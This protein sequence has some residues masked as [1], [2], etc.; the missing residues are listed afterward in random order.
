MPE[1]KQPPNQPLNQYEAAFLKRL[2][3]PYGDNRK[4]AHHLGLSVIALDARA[5]ELGIPKRPS[6]GWH[7]RQP[8]SGGRRRPGGW[9]TV[10]SFL[11][12]RPTRLSCARS[13]GDH[14]VHI[15][16]A[17]VFQVVSVKYPVP[18]A[19]GDLALFIRLEGHFHQAFFDED[20][21]ANVL[22][23]LVVVLPVL[24]VAP[25]VVGD[26]RRDGGDGDHQ[27]GR[28]RGSRPCRDRCGSGSCRHGRGDRCG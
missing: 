24:P 21:V 8:L 11:T 4:L 7:G 15:H 25:V 9:R 3:Q 13:S 28:G 23:V 17:S 1:H 19:G 14:V 22:A 27:R 12:T 20:L 5:R 18:P 10:L 2:Y 26:A 6:S 16:V